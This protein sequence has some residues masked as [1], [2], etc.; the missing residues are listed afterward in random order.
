MFEAEKASK[1]DKTKSKNCVKFGQKWPNFE[2]NFGHFPVISRKSGISA[3]ER[4]FHYLSNA[5]NRSSK[6]QLVLLHSQMAP[7]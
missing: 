2:A 6:S 7:P 4:E 1:I 5:K 3:Y